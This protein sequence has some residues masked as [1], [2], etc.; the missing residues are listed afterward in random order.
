MCVS[1]EKEAETAAAGAEE[2]TRLAAGVLFCTLQLW[3]CVS[4]LPEA[5]YWQLALGRLD[6]RQGGGTFQ[7]WFH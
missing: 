6:L 2:M 7:W 3:Y 1:S 5:A 4:R